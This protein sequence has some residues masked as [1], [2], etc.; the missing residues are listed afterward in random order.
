MTL[1]PP[2]G[3]ASLGPIRTLHAEQ[4][5]L[6]IRLFFECQWVLDL[7]IYK[8]WL[9]SLVTIKFENQG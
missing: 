9:K 5:I 7:Q 3:G 4:G 2:Y 8:K 6:L 1:T